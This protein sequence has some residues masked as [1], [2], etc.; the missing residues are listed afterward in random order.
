MADNRS[1][2]EELCLSSMR[3]MLLY[4]FAWRG[5][6]GQPRQ[7]HSI[8]RGSRLPHFGS[9]SN[10]TNFPLGGFYRMYFRLFYVGGDTPQTMLCRK[11]A[12]FG[13]LKVT[14]SLQE[15]S[16]LQTT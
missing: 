16:Y 8:A 6:L 15:D 14:A 11:C 2:R 9:A 13:A 7:P 5:W 1:M 10:P 4:V 12:A 3:E